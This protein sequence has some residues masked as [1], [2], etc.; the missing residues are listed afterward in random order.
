[1]NTFSIRQLYASLVPK[2]VQESSIE[3]QRQFMVTISIICISSFFLVSLGVVTAMQGETLLSVFDFSIATIF[4]G[5]GVILKETGKIKEISGVILSMLAVYFY[6]LFFYGGLERTT[7]VWYYTF[8]LWAIFLKGKKNGTALSIFLIATTVATYFFMLAATEEQFYS[9]N[10]MIRF[11]ASYLCVV[12]VTYVMEDTR[13]VTYARLLSSNEALS[14]SIEKLNEAQKELEEFSIKDSL[15]GLY[16]RRYFDT[17]LINSLAHSG[18]EKEGIALLLLDL[19]YF[20]NYNTHY[21]HSAGDSVLKL[22]SMQLK[23]IVA[24]NGVTI[25]R[26]GGVGFAI[27]LTNYTLANVQKICDEIITTTH[28]LS[29]THEQSPYKTLTVSIGAGCVPAMTHEL[30]V[31]EI[32]T[33]T[34]SLLAEAK[35][36]GRNR[37]AVKEMPLI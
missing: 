14:D 6:Y 17:T 32:L 26:Y 18:K 29:V 3:H 28:E 23:R 16:N 30:S 12:F 13:V 20:K 22:F 8:P 15:T 11:L 21:G 37:S 27:L 10:L 34:D 9:S 25:S 1:M 4:V 36:C 35:Q 5:L 2:D 24:S 19:D 7:W 33:F 31:H